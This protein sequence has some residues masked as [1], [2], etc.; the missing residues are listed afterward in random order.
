MRRGTQT[1]PNP[2]RYFGKADSDFAL[3]FSLICQRSSAL[4]RVFSSVFLHF[5]C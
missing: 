5:L 1:K 2:Q 4:P 3:P